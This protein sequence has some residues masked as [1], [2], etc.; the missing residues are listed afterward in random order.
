M[1]NYDSCIL[2]H[3]V[4]VTHRTIAEHLGVNQS[5]VSRALKG[6]LRIRP[7]LRERIVQQAEALGYKPHPMLSALTKMRYDQ[8]EHISGQPIA[9][10]EEDHANSTSMGDWER[11]PKAAGKQAE[12]LGFHLEVFYLCD[13]PNVAALQRVLLARGIS[14]LVIGTM[15]STTLCEQ[16]N[17]S[18]FIAVN[19]SPS[20]YNPPLYSVTLN[21]F[22]AVFLCWQK[23]VARGYQRIG[24]ILIQ[25]PKRTRDDDLREAAIL[26]CQHRYTPELI[27]IPTLFH[28]HESNT[29][30][31]VNDW[32]MTYRPDAVLGFN[33]SEWYLIKNAPITQPGFTSLHTNAVMGESSVQ[34]SGVLDHGTYSGT[35]AVRLLDLCLRS[36]LWGL[37]ADPVYHTIQPRWIE[38]NTLRAIE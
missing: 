21:H 37:P 10:I 4:I 35:E 22:E 15:K 24:A 31:R 8:S 3:G 9:F 30:Q 7:E 25:H 29:I 33:D 34:L 38:G 14:G 20:L 12:L 28:F 13:Y 16:L 32:A 1:P 6:D 26:S 36:N 17:W 19:A 23:M 5:T 27:T 2:M 18:R 11:L